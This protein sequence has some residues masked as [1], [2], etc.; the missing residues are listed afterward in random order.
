MLLSF[1]LTLN[2]GTLRRHPRRQMRREKTGMLTWPRRYW[3]PLQTSP[4]PSTLYKVEW[5]QKVHFWDNADFWCFQNWF[6]TESYF[7]CSR[8]K[9]R[10]ITKLSLFIFQFNLSHFLPECPQFWTLTI[11]GREEG[12]RLS[13]ELGNIHTCLLG[14]M[15]EDAHFVQ[16]TGKSAQRFGTCYL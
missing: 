1:I 8:T 16:V 12:R 15:L 13:P 7:F 5:D 10:I 2:Q 6:T 4:W 14:N 11:G 9:G 3:S